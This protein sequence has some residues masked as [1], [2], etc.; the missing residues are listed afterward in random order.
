MPDSRFQPVKN[1]YF[2]R[3]R[4]FPSNQEA[5]PLCPGE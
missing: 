5:E 2:T 3:E 4:L 1:D